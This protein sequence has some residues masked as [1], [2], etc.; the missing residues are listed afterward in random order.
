[1]PCVF[2]GDPAGLGEGVSLGVEFAEE[3]AV[4]GDVEC[5]VGHA[6]FI[7]FPLTIFMSGTLQKEYV[8]KVIVEIA[9]VGFWNA[10]ITNGEKQVVSGQVMRKY[11]VINPFEGVWE[12]SLKAYKLDDSSRTLNLMVISVDGSVLCTSS[13]SEK[14]SAA[15]FTVVIN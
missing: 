3:G 13:T 11:T 1:M 7:A 10:T 2:Q 4:V 12:L 8:D 5:V 14:A 6:L 9:Y 15:Y